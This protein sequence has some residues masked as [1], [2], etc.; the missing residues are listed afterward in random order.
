MPAVTLPPGSYD[1]Q[2]VFYAGSRIPSNEVFLSFWTPFDILPGRTTT[3]MWHPE[4]GLLD[5]GVAVHGPPPAPRSLTA[6]VSGNAITLTWKP[7]AP[8]VG[9][10]GAVVGDDAATNSVVGYNLYGRHGVREAFRL[11]AN[12]A[13]P[14]TSWQ[15]TDYAPCADGEEQPY[16]YVVTAFTHTNYESL[17]SNEATVCASSVDGHNA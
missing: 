12:I 11:L 14:A 9:S 17:R 10:D 13:A 2:L 15:H 1:F 16:Y 6:R 5:I 4:I 3:A 7:P 8:A